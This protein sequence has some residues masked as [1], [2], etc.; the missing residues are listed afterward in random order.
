[1][2]LRALREARRDEVIDAD[3]IR[4]GSVEA[5]HARPLQSIFGTLEV[6]RLAYRRRGQRNLYPA[7]A[8]LN[9]PVELH[10]HGLRQLSAIEACR[11]SF[12]DARDAVGR[13]T[14]VRLGKRQLE[15]LTVRAAADFEAFYA[16]PDRGRAEATDGDLLVL[17]ADGKGIVMRPDA[18]RPATAKAAAGAAGKLTTRLSKGEKRG[19]KRMAEVGAVYELTPL[20]RTPADIIGRDPE[21]ERPVAPKARNKWLT[22]SVLDDAATVIGS[23]FDEA[24]RR[25]PSQQRTWV[26]L[27]DGAKHPIERIHAEA[28]ARKI[29]VT[30][31]CDFIH[32]LEY[33]W[34][35]AWSFGTKP[36]QPPRSGS[37][38]KPSRS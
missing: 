14:G 26:A 38:A 27:V 28:E 33:I 31:V 34:A 9:L 35:A 5:G 36:T 24:Q 3:G 13:A 19:R 32:V 16:Q 30:I 10:S 8:A 21:A 6:T 20:P 1:M 11:G 22:A 7:D 4:R 29:K 37:A 23:V 15:Q 25:D 18:L 17:S 12:E 2:D